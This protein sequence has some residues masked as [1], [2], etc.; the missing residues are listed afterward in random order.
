[1]LDFKFLNF[2]IVNMTDINYYLYLL[3]ETVKN[4]MTLVDLQILVN[5]C[6]NLSYETR[7]STQ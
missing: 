6:A 7:R 3:G 4:F 2:Q 5:G 1:M